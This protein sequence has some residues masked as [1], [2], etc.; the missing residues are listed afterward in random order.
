MALGGVTNAETRTSLRPLW[1]PRGA[2][3]RSST[4][5][6]ENEQK[7]EGAMLVD[8]WYHHVIGLNFHYI[9]AFTLT[10]QLQR[11]RAVS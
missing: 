9:E 6:G 11:L 2:G 5:E 3:R 10:E 1:N 7:E 4:D 8:D